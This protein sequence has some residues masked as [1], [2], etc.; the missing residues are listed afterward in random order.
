MLDKIYNL[1][2]FILNQNM[3]DL[4]NCGETPGSLKSC[5]KKPK[6]VFNTILLYTTF[7]FHYSI[8]INNYLTYD[9]SII[10]LQEK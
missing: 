5:A 6:V 2:L 3:I 10:V 7:L 9:I 4:S 8:Q 1:L